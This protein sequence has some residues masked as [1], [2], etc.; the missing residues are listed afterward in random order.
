M[1]YT[2]QTGEKIMSLIK[3][4][5][6]KTV[7]D[8]GSQQLYGVAGYEYGSFA[9]TL[10]KMNGIEYACIDLN[11][12]NNAHQI[13]LA[14]PISKEDSIGEVD[15]VVNCGTI[16]HVPGGIYQPFKT[17]HELCKVG[18]IMV[19]EMPKTGNWLLHGNY[20]FDHKFYKEL[21]K[22][23]G[24]EVLDLYEFPAMGNVTDGWT[25]GAVFKKTKDSKFPTK[26]D[27]NIEP[28]DK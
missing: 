11:G 19:H 5:K 2:S 1:G 21:A 24:Y 3:T 25:T 28:Y 12:E 26:K 13:D 7:I 23:C 8:L 4:H 22:V 27:F 14:K 15:M 6:P 20:W 9:S 17:V 10:Y 16:E 18:G